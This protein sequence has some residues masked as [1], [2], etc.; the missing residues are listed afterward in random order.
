VTVPTADRFAALSSPQRVRVLRRLVEAARLG[1]IPAVVPPAGPGPARLSPAQEALWTYETLYPGS[2]LNLC[3]A[4][5]LEHAAVVADLEA[6]LSV[7]T[8]HHDVLRMRITGPA[9]D[10]RVEYPPPAPFRLERLDP[11]GGAEARHAALVAFGRRP[12]DL[13]RG[14]LFRGAV[15]VPPD[16][17]PTLVLAMHH[18][19]GDW[20]SFDVLHREFVAAYQ[21][22]RSG[23]APAHARPRLQYA[24]FA[25]WQHELESAGVFAA[26]LD[27]WREYL[28]D[29]PPPLAPGSPGDGGY[30]QLA[31]PID[32]R[33]AAGVRRLAAERDATPYAVL[34][35]AFAVLTRR[36]TGR[37]DFVL[38]TP[39]ANRDARGL[40]RVLGYVMNVMPT[41]WRIGPRDTYAAVL[42]RFAAGLPGLL[43]RAG[44]PAGRIVSAV[45][46]QRRLG[47]SPLYQWI[48]M[49]LPRPA[50]LGALHEVCRPERIETGG[51]H[52]LVCVVRDGDGGGFEAA[53]AYRAGVHPAAEV[54]EWAAAFTALLA[55]VLA[56]P[57]TPAGGVTV[58]PDEEPAAPRPPYRPPGTHRERVLCELFA[59]A[60]GAAR[61]GAD[62]DVFEL[63][64]DSIAVIMMVGRA[65]AAG[66]ELTTRDVFL[67][68]TPARV[69]ELA[70]EVAVTAAAGPDTGVGRF[71]PTPAVRRWLDS[72][73]DLD[74][75]VLSVRFPVRAGL[76]E[77]RVR[78]AVRALV[79]RHAALRMRVERAAGGWELV[80]P[81]EPPAEPE[82]VRVDAAA[83]GDA[84]VR[85]TPGPPRLDPRTGPLL[86]VAWFD[87]GP[88]RAGELLLAVHHLA[89]DGVSMRLLCQDLGELL[90]AGRVA[91]PAPPVSFRSWAGRLHERALA[92]ADGLPGWLDRLAEPA[93]RLVPGGAPVR[94][95]ARRTLTL[96]RPADP[97][98]GKAPASLHCG[99]EDVLL[100][101]L[102]AAALRRR[103]TGTALL[104]ELE[105]HGRDALGDAVDVAATVGW[106]TAQYPVRL[107]AG[108]AAAD[109]FWSGGDAP[110]LALVRVRDQ[111]R[112]ARA[113]G[114]A[115]GMLRHANPET[116]P[117]LAALPGP[118]LSFNYLGRFTR[119]ELSDGT[120]PGVTDGGAPLHHLVEL[121][122]VAEADRLVASWSYPAGAVPDADVRRLA[123]DWFSALDILVA[124]AAGARISSAYPLVDL[125]DDQ[126]DALSHQDGGTPW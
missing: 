49:Y 26:Q 44:V 57:S 106:F 104:I 31:F 112:R 12:F 60:T 21:L 19:V 71:A 83:P 109:A 88:R 39:T 42:D 93:A 45:D 16:A 24:D 80:V 122:V 124:R 35:A 41:R 113:G 102:L 22:V 4:Y 97:V 1:D 3:C 86:R 74:G 59:E 107:D 125:T 25:G 108:Q 2:A 91:A 103:G 105:G 99:P 95:G 11:A 111:L 14:E 55:E 72:G 8:A 67:G 89:A 116:A 84:G 53:L 62:D 119:E 115:Y 43:A 38:G 79:E 114:A 78:R 32:A 81:G 123:G 110:R 52:D 64:A 28:A 46:P 94:A 27:F 13:D 121:T 6:A 126:I 73:D 63:G 87:R 5:H 40:D 18:V 75:P 51:E 7:V 117:V 33:I 48:F 56:D 92:L 85:A 10:L 20:W 34:M 50:G 9:G 30:E 77:A 70:R 120:G 118:D 37:G 58:T 68:G 82:V 66:L 96:Q 65:R 76:D 100:T 47:R 15:L 17:H 90:A 101:A 61:V 54:R 29:P 23:T 69:A 98:V 36:L